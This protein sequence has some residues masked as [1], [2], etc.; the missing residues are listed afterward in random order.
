MERSKK[1]LLLC[2]VVVFTLGYSVHGSGGGGAAAAADTVYQP[3]CHLIENVAD[4]EQFDWFYYATRSRRVYKTT[5]WKAW[6]TKIAVRR[7]VSEL[8][9]C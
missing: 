2:V 1:L 9:A 7:K 8:S 3:V 4:E 5:R 6:C